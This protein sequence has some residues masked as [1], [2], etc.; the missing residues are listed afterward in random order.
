MV[1][2][3]AKRAGVDGLRGDLK[4]SER[5]ACQLAGLNRSTKRYTSM[6]TEPP[7]LRMRLRELAAQRRRFGYRRLAV[8]LRR[9]GFH[10][11]HKRVYRMYREENLAVR[12]K[13]RR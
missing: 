12:R 1:G 6:R 9:E 8:M 4:F 2:P 7:K 10:V 3:A 11:N 5:R 13:S